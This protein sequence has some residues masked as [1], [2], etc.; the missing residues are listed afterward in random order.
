MAADPCGLQIETSSSPSYGRRLLVPGDRRA[1]LEAALG[2]FIVD[3]GDG[4]VQL[5]DREKA[6][7]TIW[8]RV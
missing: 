7:A 5:E 3:L 2:P 4:Q 1:D 8:W 6:L